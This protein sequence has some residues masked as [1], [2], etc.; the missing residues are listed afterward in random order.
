MNKLIQSQASPTKISPEMLSPEETAQ[1]IATVFQRLNH[2]AN[3]QGGLE[4]LDTNQSF[5]KTFF[6]NDEYVKS[7]ENFIRKF[8]GAQMT[9]TGY[10]MPLQI[11]GKIQ[12]NYNKTQFNSVQLLNHSKKRSRSQ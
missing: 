7:A 5:F 3:V 9:N 8:K 12:P 4:Q 2:T 1:L 11:S 10:N 6:S